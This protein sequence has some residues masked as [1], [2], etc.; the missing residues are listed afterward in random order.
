[1]NCKLLITRFQLKVIN[2]T[3]QMDTY[4]WNN[5]MMG[6]LIEIDHL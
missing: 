2:S 5:T 3:F 6:E 4:K 1:M